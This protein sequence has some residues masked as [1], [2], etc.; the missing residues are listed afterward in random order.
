MGFESWLQPLCKIK[1]K[2][3]TI[4]VHLLLDPFKGESLV[5]WNYLLVN[6]DHDIGSLLFPHFTLFHSFFYIFPTFHSFDNNLYLS[7]PPRHLAFL[8][9]TLSPA[10]LS[11]PFLSLFTLKTYTY[12]PTNLSSPIHQHLK[13]NYFFSG[14]NG[15]VCVDAFSSCC[16]NRD[17]FPRQKPLPTK[18]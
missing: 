5:G 7:W 4:D 17:I 1:V 14:F 10:S 12:L 2:L 13:N 3:C 8:R 15:C 6:I 16:R 9:F 18:G 11:S